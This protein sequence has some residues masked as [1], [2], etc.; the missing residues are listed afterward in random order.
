MGDIGMSLELVITPVG[1]G[2]R[3]QDNEGRLPSSFYRGIEEADEDAREYLAQRGGGRLII[4]EGSIAI[5]E[6]HIR[7]DQS[8]DTRRP[9]ASSVGLEAFPQD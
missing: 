4:R 7:P 8:G 3:V 9:G 5:S 1:R 6:V 2:W